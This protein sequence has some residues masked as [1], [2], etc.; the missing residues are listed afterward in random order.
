MTPSS[1]PKRFYTSATAKKS[2]AGFTVELDGRPIKTPAR[3]TL[4]VPTENLANAIAAEWDQQG[5]KLDL[6]SM[7]LTRLANVALDRT[8]ETRTDLAEEVTNYASTDVVC[9]LTDTPLGLRERQD[10]AWRPLRDWAGQSL[11]MLLVPVTGLIAAPQPVASLEAAMQHAL[12]LDDFRLTGLAWA[13]SLFGSAVLALALE[14]GRISAADALKFSCIDEDWQVEHW[15]E[16]DD[17]K[18]ARA[19]RERDALSLGTWFEALST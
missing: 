16:D 9:F 6:P 2:K 4:A 5:E 1:L 10:A 8:P 7:T 19:A 3:K 12:S 18:L 17:A 13:C 14:Q 11:N 15:G